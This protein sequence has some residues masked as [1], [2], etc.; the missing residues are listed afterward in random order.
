M[1]RLEVTKGQTGQLV[2]FRA[3]EGRPSATPSVGLKD[4]GGA[5]LKASSTTN[6]TLDTVNTTVNAT[7]AAGVKQLTVASGTGIVRGRTYRV[8]NALGQVE[9]VRVVGITGTTVTLDEP[10]EYAY[11]AADAFQATEFYYTLQTADVAILRELCVATATYSVTGQVTG[12]LLAAFDVVLHPLA[13]PLTVERLKERWPDVAAQE[14]TEQR[15]EDFAR[16]R[17]AAWDLVRRGLRHR[18]FRPA[19]VVTSE[20]LC[21]WGL[22]ELALILQEGG[23][24]VV[25]NLQGLEALNYIRERRQ[26][27]RDAALA[28][29]HFVDL[30]EDE[31][32]NEEREY[33]PLT[34]DFVR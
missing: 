33:K 1:E 3:T 6:V 12:P 18:G 16:Q 28:N 20:D 30:D 7:A 23:V 27:E 10:T 32:L 25:R 5:V 11:A 19:C 13:N 22:W 29:L 14:Q 24:R 21:E 34:L 17:V 31:A 15:G 4:S 26:Q 2:W 8:Q 9:W